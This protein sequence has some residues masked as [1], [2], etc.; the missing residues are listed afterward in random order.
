MVIHVSVGFTLS[1][2]YDQ[3]LNEYELIVFALTVCFCLAAI[4]SEQKKIENSY[5]ACILY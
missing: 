5:F 1:P 4:V 2:I 3:G